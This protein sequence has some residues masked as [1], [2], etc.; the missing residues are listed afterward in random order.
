MKH[1]CTSMVTTILRG[2]IAT[3]II[4]KNCEHPQKCSNLHVENLSGADGWSQCVS[5]DDLN[6]QRVVGDL[7]WVL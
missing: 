7:A 2:K 1:A 6:V 4:E 5:R 3:G